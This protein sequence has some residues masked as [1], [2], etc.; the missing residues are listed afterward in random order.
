MQNKIYFGDN[1]IYGGF[2]SFSDEIFPHYVWKKNITGI[3]SKRKI[4]G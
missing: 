1:L 2:S 4:I 3:G